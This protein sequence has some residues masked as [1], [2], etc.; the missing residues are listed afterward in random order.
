MQMQVVRGPGKVPLGVAE[1]AILRAVG[2]YHYLSAR[3]TTRALVYSPGSLT[4]I[5]SK[6]KRLVDAG[7]LQRIFLPRANQHAGSS[8]LV[9][10]LASRGR[11]YLQDMGLSAPSRQR[12]SEEAER[13]RSLLFLPHTLAVNDFLI[14]A[15]LLS[16]RYPEVSLE[17]MIHERGLRREPVYVSE[18]GRIV[19]IVPDGWIDLLLSGNL[20]MCLV[21]EL[22]RGTV[23][24]RAW[25]RKIRSLLAYAR[26]PYQERFGTTSL[27]VAVVTTAGEKR[28]GSLL[29]WTEA[30]IGTDCGGDADLFRLTGISAEEASPEAIF[31]Q[32]VWYRPGDE[33]PVPLLEG[34]AEGP[35]PGKDAALA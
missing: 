16:L 17:G 2:R 23:E 29:R 13:E 3:Q 7:F 31:G 35:S 18:K 26:G 22:D 30:E 9:Y 21:L 14:A 19:P 27:T 15:D 25:R 11:H 8:P 6:L 20:Q 4:L 28:L 10:S 1:D 12:P 5:Q 24:Q 32:P 33:A 34:I